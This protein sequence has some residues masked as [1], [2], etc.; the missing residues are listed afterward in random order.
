MLDTM[1]IIK[2]PDFLNE[3]RKVDEIFLGIRLNM[4]AINFISA[5][6]FIKYTL[7]NKEKLLRI[8]RIEMYS[9][10][11]NV[12][13]FL[14]QIILHLRIQHLLS[15]NEAYYSIK[16]NQVVVLAVVVTSYY[17]NRYLSISIPARDSFNK[18]TDNLL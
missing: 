17:I 1:F 2:T 10:V 16:L 3:T 13:S 5:F 15:H 9:I 8:M 4:N 18:P 12:V 11:I 7:C 6:I 14:L